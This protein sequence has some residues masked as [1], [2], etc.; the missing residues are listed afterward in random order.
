MPEHVHLLVYPEVEQYS[1]S[2]I[3][4]YLKEPFAR[5]VVKHWEQNAPEMLSRIEVKRGSRT[6]RRFWQEGGGYD[7]NLYNWETIRKAVDYIEQNPVR[8]GLAEEP[9]GWMWSS[10]QARAGMADA[11]LILDEFEIVD[12]I[13]RVDR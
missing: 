7:R 5:R 9:I 6:V 11:P 2:Q 13:V 4:R 1:M 10:A 12:S 3:L 8:R